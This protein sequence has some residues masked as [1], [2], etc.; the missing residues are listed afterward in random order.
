M[1]NN[2]FLFCIG[3]S[4]SRVLRALT[5]LLA[6]GTE[7][8]AEKI[9]PIIIDPDR[10]NGDL[11]RTLETIKK[12]QKIR[13]KIEFN[14]NGFFKANIQ[15]LA[16]LQEATSQDGTGLMVP[17]GFKYEFD[18]TAAGRFGDFLKM[19]TLDDENQSLI[20]TLFSEQNL[21]SDLSVG[22]KG[23]PHMGSVVLNQ[24]RNS[25]DFKYFASRLNERDRVFIISSI[26]GG[27]GAAG[28][29]LLVKNIREAGNEIPNHTRLSNIPLGAVTVMPYFGV[30]P[31][32]KIAIDK[33]TFISKTKAALSYYEHHLTGNRSLN[34]MY[35]LADKVTADM[36]ASEG[37]KDQKNNAHYIEML[38]ALAVIDYLKIPDE[39]LQCVNGRAIEPI[40][41]EYGLVNNDG[42]ANIMN[43]LNLGHETRKTIAKP[44]TQYAYSIYYW[45]KHLQ[46]AIAG[47]NRQAYAN[48]SFNEDFLSS[49]FYRDQLKVFNK[50]FWEWLQEMKRNERSFNPI[51]VEMANDQLHNFLNG[52]TQK[53]IGNPLFGRIDWNFVQFDGYLNSIDKTLNKLPAEKKLLALFY[54]A[55]NQIYQE[56][57]KGILTN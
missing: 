14:Q 44:L 40:Y 38:A 30:E 47:A 22:F 9:I 15:T 27:T 53:K 33:N 5:F 55:T 18:G 13:E 28:F 41:K 57:I 52:I 49:P 20:N 48:N 29:P 35:Y 32:Q 19:G 51:N 2:L 6:A 11:N 45:E 8:N 12:Y 46:E 37:G 43:F 16:S 4:G 23:N 1:T 10:E 21:S 17:E 34:A 50:N 56:R 42:N 36:P 31:N 24:F 3:G 25:N 54:K 39:E 7:I 26:F